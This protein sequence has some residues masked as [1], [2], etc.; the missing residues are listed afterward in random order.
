[1]VN[2]SNL[3]MKNQWDQKQKEQSLKTMTE[4]KDLAIQILERTYKENK[5]QGGFLN[6]NNVFQR[7]SDKM[8]RVTFRMIEPGQGNR[9]CG[10]GNVMAFAINYVG[11]TMNICPIGLFQS[12]ELLAQ[13]FI[14]EASHLVIG[15]N[16]CHATIIETIALHF[17]DFSEALQNGYW[18]K[19]NTNEL[20]QKVKARNP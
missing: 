5:Y 12:K 8:K 3:Q 13:I 10:E 6:Q 17:S 14:H 15:G 19:C 4:A 9:F 1:M 2:L 16:E 20:L 18:E 11:D 7:V